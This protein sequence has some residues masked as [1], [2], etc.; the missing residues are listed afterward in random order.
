MTLESRFWAKVDKNGPVPATC[1]DLGPCWLWIGSK[2][3]TGYGKLFVQR[4]AP[5]A[6]ASRVSF[7]LAHGP[8][9]VDKSTTHG[10]CVLHRCDV[11]SCVNPAHLFLG[12]Q[13][14]NM[15]D[16]VSKGRHVSMAHPERLARGDRNGQRL[17][18]ERTIRGEEHH[19]AKLTESDVREIQRCRGS[20]E[21]I[22]AIASALGLTSSAVSRVCLGKTWRHV[23]PDKDVAEAIR[24]Q[25]KKVAFRGEE[26]TCAAWARRTG[27]S[28]ATIRGRIASGWPADRALSEPAFAPTTIEWRGVSRT[29]KDWSME[30]G[31]DEKAIRKR[32]GR[33]WS[34]DQALSTPSSRGNR[35]GATEPVDAPIKQIVRTPGPMT[36]AIVGSR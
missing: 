29:M 11:P 32:L 36:R 30:T 10:V 25:S 4:G 2:Q 33:G 19:S 7:E 26:L 22:G 6:T 13:Q 14:T 34:V 31:I 18:P 5:P 35:V 24:A 9:P 23:R 8:I 21:R 3:P 20:G 15:A 27:I 17:H 1:P 28:E 12:S 16:M